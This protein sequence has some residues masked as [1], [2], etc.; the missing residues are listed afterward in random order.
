M[1]SAVMN[2]F[3]SHG[4]H[5]PRFLCSVYVKLEV[6][7]SHIHHLKDNAKLFSRKMNWVVQVY[8]LAGSSLFFNS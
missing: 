1:H 4:A 5:V 6:L 8:I 3:V 2:S 7:G